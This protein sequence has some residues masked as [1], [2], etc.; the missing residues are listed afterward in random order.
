[1]FYQA[2]IDSRQSKA[3]A[4]EIGGVTIQLEPL[5]GDYLGNLKRMAQA[6]RDAVK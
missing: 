6:F 4:E 5:S 1:V 2:E 3:F